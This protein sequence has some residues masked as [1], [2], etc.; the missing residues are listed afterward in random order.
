M[1]SEGAAGA[2]WCA[3]RYNASRNVLPLS[4]QRWAFF[5]TVVLTIVEMPAIIVMTVMKRNPQVTVD[6]PD[7]QH[8]IGAR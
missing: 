5:V 2:D 4:A 1:A 8:L 3:A 7:K 6:Q